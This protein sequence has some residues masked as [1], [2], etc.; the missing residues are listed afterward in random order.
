[1][2]K[3]IDFTQQDVESFL[4]RIL[5]IRWTFAT[6]YNYESKLDNKDA[7]EH[8]SKDHWWFQEDIPSSEKKKYYQRNRKVK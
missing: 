1:V 4:K 6:V 7:E 2:R 5:N 3:E 8:E